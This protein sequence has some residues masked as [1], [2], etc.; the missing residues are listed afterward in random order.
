MNSMKK[1]N[2]KSLKQLRKRIRDLKKLDLEYFDKESVSHLINKLF[3]ISKDFF[4]QK[5]GIPIFRS[6]YQK[7]GAE[8]FDRISRIWYNPEPEYIERANLKGKE[9]GYG[10]NALD[11]SAIESCQYSLRN[12]K[13]REFSLTIGSWIPQRDLKIMIV[14]N[15]YKAQKIGNDLRTAYKELRKSKKQELIKESKTKS[16]NKELRAWAYRKA[17]FSDQFAKEDINSEKNYLF[18][19]LLANTIFNS[20]NPSI[21][22]IW[23]P[24]VAYQYKGFNI[25]YKSQLIREKDLVLHEVYHVV[26]SF[27]QNIKK[28]PKIEIISKTSNFKDDNIIWPS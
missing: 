3:T 22:C 19:A 13:E 23:Y 11:I 10:A 4:A 2:P 24:S 26:I 15:S 7:K 6:C 1:V 25:A 8:P 27:F 18:S 14:C 28:Y 20:T 17:F 12:T 9:I 21:D 5:K 16:L